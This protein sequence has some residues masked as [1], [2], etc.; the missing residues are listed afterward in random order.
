MK[1][2]E[3]VAQLLAELRE[4]TDNDFERHRI[5]VLERDL[6]APPTVEQIDD[7]RQR[8]NGVIYRKNKYGH[9]VSSYGIHR[10]V[11]IYYHGDIPDSYHIHHING[12]KADNTFENLQCLTKAEH[13]AIH[14]SSIENKLPRKSTLVCKNCGNEYIGYYSG[15]NAFCS[16][17]CRKNF[18]SKDTVCIICGKTFK[19]RYHAKFCSAECMGKARRVFHECLFCGK[20][21]RSHHPKQKY[22]SRECFTKHKGQKEHPNPR[23]E[24]ICVICGK[25][26]SCNKYARSRTCSKQCGSKLSWQ[27]R[28]ENSSK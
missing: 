2:P 27:K 5:D 8:F 28:R 3:R 4:L 6:T 20:K 26:F 21:F 22:C 23:E 17:E 24:R 15:N 10:A 11:W 9:F 7:K 13:Q 12:N 25:T 16:E 1:N 14:A 19:T 18:Y